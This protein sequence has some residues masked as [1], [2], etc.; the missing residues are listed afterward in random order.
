MT[1]CSAFI[2]NYRQVIIVQD[3]VATNPITG[4]QRGLENKIIDLNV[5][6]GLLPGM[7]GAGLM[8]VSGNPYFANRV[9]R[10]LYG[11]EF[12]SNTKLQDYVGEVYRKIHREETM[13]QFL[14]K[15]D[16]DYGYFRHLFENGKLSERLEEE[17]LARMEGRVNK[18]P[19]LLLVSAFD[20]LYHFDGPNICMI[21]NPGNTIFE[22]RPGKILSLA[23]GAREFDARMNSGKRA[24]RDRLGELTLDE[25]ILEMLNAAESATENNAGVGTPYEFGYIERTKSKDKNSTDFEINAVRLDKDRFEMFRRKKR[26]LEDEKGYLKMIPREVLCEWISHVRDPEIKMDGIIAEME[27]FDM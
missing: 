2:P 19:D 25:G 18:R 17:Y 15:F 3:S 22:Y 16:N 6:D 26:E 9:A 20:G 21:S 13:K 24:Y 12:K 8:G 27:Q 4:Q 1:L 11:Q 5:D 23:D 10:E 7:N 14:L